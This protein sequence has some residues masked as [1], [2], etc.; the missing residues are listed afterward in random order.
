[1]ERLAVMD[2]SAASGA[3]VASDYGA[4]TGRAMAATRMHRGCRMT[5]V[6]ARDVG[7]FR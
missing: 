2:T 5:A 3:L 7:W 6:A 4:C 1:V